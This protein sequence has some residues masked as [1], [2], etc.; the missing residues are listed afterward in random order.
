[1]V[2]YPMILE[3]RHNLQLDLTTRTWTIRIFLEAKRI[4]LIYCITYSYQ[5]Q[6]NKAFTSQESQV[7][8]SECL[9]MDS[10]AGIQRQPGFA[11]LQSGKV[12]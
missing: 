5:T 3:S 7:L 11:R 12:S 10:M 9:Q 1:M 2:D 6:A 8:G 4:T